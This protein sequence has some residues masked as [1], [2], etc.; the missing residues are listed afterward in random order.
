MAKAGALAN[1]G[2]TSADPQLPDAGP[3]DVM[4]SQEPASGGV[5][6]TKWTAEEIAEWEEKVAQVT[7]V[8]QPQR[9]RV[10]EAGVYD[11][12][13]PPEV[14]DYATAA[15]LAALVADVEQWGGHPARVLV[16]HDGVKRFTDTQLDFQL[17]M[18]ESQEPAHLVHEMPDDPSNIG[19]KLAGLWQRG[20]RNRSGSTSRTFARAILGSAAAL[21]SN[22]AVWI[23][24]LD[25]VGHW[26]RTREAACR[27]LA[28]R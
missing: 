18:L 16:A 17:K 5:H 7:R 2:V 28:A 6:D 15:A 24:P 9:K 21:Q 11:K 3:P 27:G 25:S 1:V 4:E 19:T 20:N 22:R 26:Q 8:A 13:G 23:R 14:M 10:S 12:R